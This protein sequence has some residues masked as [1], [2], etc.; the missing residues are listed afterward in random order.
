MKFIFVLLF[1][2]FSLSFP[3]IEFAILLGL[4]FQLSLTFSSFTVFLGLKPKSYEIVLL[5]GFNFGVFAP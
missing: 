3:E 4:S 2:L 1:L 5:L